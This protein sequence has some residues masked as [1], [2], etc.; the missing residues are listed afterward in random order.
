[1]QK[2][3]SK[4]GFYIIDKNFENE[5]NIE[6]NIYVSLF[7]KNFDKDLII[8]IWE[9]SK[10]DMYCFF[11]QIC[12]ENIKIIQNYNNSILNLKSLFF[13][14][15]KNLSSNIISQINS[16][17]S[18]SFLNIVS[19]VKENKI[20]I[21]SWIEVKKNS[22]KI[23]S[24]LEL[25][26]IFVWNNGKIK[27]TPNLFIESNEVKISHSSKS[28]RL[29]DDKLFYL[30]SRWLDKKKSTSIMIESYFIKIFS[31]LKMFD[32]KIL[33]DIFIYL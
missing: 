4:T 1:M 11:T 22:K 13:D 6:K 2:N 18:K 25:E 30:K 23:E 31:C 24:K 16:N 14:S 10:V 8:D 29:N 9:N 3:I 32:E 15:K 7:M 17:N 5:I 27:S 26:N 20:E 19:I 12:P 28:H 21:N 33:K